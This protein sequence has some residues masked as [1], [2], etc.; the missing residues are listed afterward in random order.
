MTNTNEAHWT[1]R[2]PPL[3]AFL[4]AVQFMTRLWTPRD[5]N[6][7][8][9]DLARGAPYFPAVG[10]LVGALVAGLVQALLY[11]TPLAPG[12][13]AVC[14]LVASV[15]LT[16]AFHEDGL[17]DVADGL[18]GGQG[19]EARLRI[20]RDSRIG[21]YAG[22]ALI[23]LF[24]LRAACLWGTEPCAWWQALVLAHVLG[25]YSTLC[26]LKFSPYA[27]ESEPGLGK[28]MVEGLGFGA[29]I[30]ATLA[31]AAFCA[32]WSGPLG[33]GALGFVVVLT[34][35]LRRMFHA[36]IGGITGDCLGAANVACEALTLLVFAAALPA[37][38]SPWI[39]R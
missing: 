30:L 1:R 36:A 27:R 7:E 23:L 5:L 24:A 9:R 25:R 3:F 38:A 39:G 13:V 33:L 18:G 29:L 32:W 22:I 19:R 15:I 4:V 11:C 34:F 35:A 12:V 10:L 6:P 37:T 14:A 31:T 17:A 16:G 21:S 2:V 20:M 8:K 26:L 28:P